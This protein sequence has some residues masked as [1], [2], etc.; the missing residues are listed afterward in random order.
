MIKVL[1]VCLGNICRSPSAEGIMKKLIEEENLGEKIII[2]SAGTSHWH[3]GELP[4][5]LM[6]KA[7]SKRGYI[8]ESK[9]RQIKPADLDKFDY[10]VAMDKN[11]YED[12]TMLLSFKKEHKSKLHLITD[13]LNSMDWDG[14]P[15]PYG[16]GS[17]QFDL[18]IDILEESCANFLEFIKKENNL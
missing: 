8:L 2:D 1:F 9:S 4:D 3:V 15:D 16:K 7:A 6:R 5:P 13:Y 18:V 14:V 12:I 17:K 11:N 10:I